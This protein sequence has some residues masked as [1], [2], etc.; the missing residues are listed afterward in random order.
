M[1]K[2]KLKLFTLLLSSIFLLNFNAYPADCDDLSKYIKNAGPEVIDNYKGIYSDWKGNQLA[3]GWNEY[4]LAMIGNSITNAVPY[5]SVFRNGVQ[6][7]QCQWQE[8]EAFGKLLCGGISGNDCWLWHDKGGSYGNASGMKASWGYSTGSPNAIKNLKPMWSIVMFGTNDTKGGSFGLNMS[9]SGG[10]RG[11][12]EQLLA[13]NIMPIVS[14]IPPMVKEPIHDEL[15][16]RVRDSI[17][18]IA[19]EYNII[20]L[21]LLQ[22]FIDFG[23]NGGKSLMGD[24]LHPSTAVDLCGGGVK[25]N[26]ECLRVGGYNLRTKLSTDV[27]ML[28]NDQVVG[29]GSSAPSFTMNDPVVL[30]NYHIQLDFT[31]PLL[32]SSAENLS[33]YFIKT[34]TNI[35]SIVLRNETEVHIYLNEPLL[36]NSPA[37]LL[38]KDIVAADGTVLASVYKIPVSGTTVSIRIEDKVSEKSMSINNMPNPFNPSTTI[39]FSRHGENPFEI[40]IVNQKG[41]VV[42]SVSKFY[43]NAYLWYAQ[44]RKGHSLPSGMYFLRAK[45]DDRVYEHK[46][47]IFK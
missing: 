17:Q 46:M 2:L 21:D 39:N 28:L 37:D 3:S 19:E 12:I 14:A 32:E 45:T 8:Y 33:N 27:L 11:I 31:L 10:M 44:D 6:S 22:A 26:P 29:G 9:K 16:R 15:V 7:S 34:P 25:F 41:E 30:D 18:V 35:D 40:E 36:L 5:M 42:E 1:I 13:E 24:A 20:W 47:I 23:S 4:R 43:G 38:V